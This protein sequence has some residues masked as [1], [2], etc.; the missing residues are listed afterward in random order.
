MRPDLKTQIIAQ[1]AR[2]ELEIVTDNQISP[3]G[4]PFKFVRLPGT[5][6]DPALYNARKRR[7]NLGALLQ[8]HFETQP[9]G[10]VKETYIC[11]AMPPAQ[12]ARRGGDPQD[13]EGRVCLCN[14]LLATA[15]YA[16]ETEPPLVTLGVSG[17]QVTQL[18]TARQV[19]EEILTPEYVA[20]R[21]QELQIRE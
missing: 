3:T 9:D 18:L 19:V 1:N 4:Y 13:T 7:C 14:A 15:G 8:S 2:G 11:S 10:T 6:S 5:L 12:Y 16:P 17:K 20:R 21:E